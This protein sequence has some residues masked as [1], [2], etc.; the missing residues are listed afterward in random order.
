[1]DLLDCGSCEE[2]KLGV[3]ASALGL[4]AI[5]GL[6]NAAAW[7]SRHER[8]LALNALFYAALAAWEQ[9]HVVQHLK[10]LRRECPASPAADE[11]A[12]AAS[13]VRLA[14]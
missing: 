3:H 11:P 13:A 7:L 10:E 14:A 4:A 5:M 9:Q 6:Y 8:H 1:M 12:T 2:L